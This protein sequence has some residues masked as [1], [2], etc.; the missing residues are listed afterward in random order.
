[1]KCLFIKADVVLLS[2]L[3]FD[4]G[5]IIGTNDVFQ[6]IVIQLD[7]T[8]KMVSSKIIMMREDLFTVQNMQKSIF[9]LQNKLIIL[10]KFDWLKPIAGLFH[11]QINL[12]TMIFNKL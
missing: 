6:T 4:K 9:Q 3:T 7:L 12:F 11:L 1:M 2:T 8:N 10:D 5:T